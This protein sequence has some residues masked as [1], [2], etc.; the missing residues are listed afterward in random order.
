MD[1]EA[2]ISIMAAIIYASEK[3]YTAEG[4]VNDAV[5]ILNQVTARRG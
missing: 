1:K 4:A 3:D 2:L 5:K